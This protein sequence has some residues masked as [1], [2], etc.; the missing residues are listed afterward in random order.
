MEL[1][2]QDHDGKYPLT[3]TA[4]VPKYLDKMP[5]CNFSR[6]GSY[7]LVTGPGVGYNNGE[8][9]QDGTRAEP[10]S[11]YYLIW[12]EGDRHHRATGVP[13]NYPQYDGIRGLMER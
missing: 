10:F 6:P 3:L 11:H 12:C 4:L 13:V 1:Y 5:E 8:L 2:S 9:R 7:R